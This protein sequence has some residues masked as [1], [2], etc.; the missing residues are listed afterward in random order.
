MNKKLVRFSNETLYR[1]F[2]KTPNCFLNNTF[3]SLVNQTL[4]IPFSGTLMSLLTKTP[5]RLLFLILVGLSC[6]C[7]KLVDLNLDEGK[8]QIIIEGNID[9]HAGVQSVRIS[10]SVPVSASNDFP[11]VS[12]ARVTVSDNLGNTFKF[13]E[14]SPGVYTLFNVAGHSGRTYTLNVIVD[15]Q[16]YTAKSTMPNA[17]VLDSLTA[18]EEE[19]GKETRTTVAVNYKD[20]A[21]VLN[22]YLFKMT[23]NGIPVSRIFSDSDFFTDGRTVKRDLYL[24]DN[25]DVEIKPQ[26]NVGIEML[27][28]D[29]PV[30]TYWRTLEQQYSSGNPNDVTTPSNPP[31]NLSNNALG[32]FSAH[33]SQVTS[34]VISNR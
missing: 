19:F 13:N 3:Y 14:T 28:I 25:A 10:R 33:T 12:G 27:C 16:T 11:Q 5:I 30:Y 32:Y 18:S 21:N 29:L 2:T 23:I 22:Y 9:N 6:S 15:E 20:P 17:V 34:V 8:Q 31:N 26:D 24:T 1:F 4:I 7:K